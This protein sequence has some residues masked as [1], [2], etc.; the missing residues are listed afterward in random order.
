MSLM[1]NDLLH[2]QAAERDFAQ[3]GDFFVASA[4]T[5]SKAHRAWR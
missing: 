5:T 1:R 4:M 2:A 3:A